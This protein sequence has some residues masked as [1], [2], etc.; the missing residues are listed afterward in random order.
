MELFEPLSQF[1]KD[2]SETLLVLQLSYWWPQMANL[3]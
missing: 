2:K 3:L 1:L